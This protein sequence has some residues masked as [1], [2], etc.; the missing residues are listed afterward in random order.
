MRISP[1]HC[2]TG[3]GSIS[4]GPARRWL[5]HGAR[6]FRREDAA[7]SGTPEPPLAAKRAVANEGLSPLAPLGVLRPVTLVPRLVPCLVAGRS[8]G[9][10]RFLRR[11][12]HLEIMR[13]GVAGSHRRQEDAVMGW[14]DIDCGPGIR[15]FG[16]R[17]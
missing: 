3:T 8:G 12:E 6:E 15:P 7:I 13:L 16:G 10:R 14:A 5:D 9:Q 2:I 4:R 17:S 11:A 1:T